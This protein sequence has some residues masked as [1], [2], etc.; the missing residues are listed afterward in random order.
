[1]NELTHYHKT[2]IDQVSTLGEGTHYCGIFKGYVG[3]TKNK[4]GYTAL[5][6]S[7]EASH[8][9]NWGSCVSVHFTDDGSVYVCES[10]ITMWL[11]RD[12]DIKLELIQFMEEKMAK[13]VS[14][15]SKSEPFTKDEVIDK[16]LNKVGFFVLAVAIVISYFILSDLY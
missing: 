7:G 15:Q 3:I 14:R 10:A 12:E 4:D 5:W 11:V 8:D 2:F 6:T 16:R 13:A 1:M 9:P